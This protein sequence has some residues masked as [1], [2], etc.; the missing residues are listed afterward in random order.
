MK[1]HDR[2]S[3][4]KYFTAGTLRKILE[5]RRFRWSSPRV[6]NDPF[7]HLFQISMED[8]PRSLR[9][10]FISE[11]E[12]NIFGAEEPDIPHPCMHSGMLLMLRKY[13]PRLSR[14]EVLSELGHGFDEGVIRSEEYLRSVKRT[15]EEA[16]RT[17]RIFCVSEEPNNF[18]MWAHY[19][20]QHSGAVVE[21]RCIEDLDTPLCAARKV[22]YRTRMPKLGSN[23]EIL[24]NALGLA[25]EP[26]NE[27]LY[28]DLAFVKSDH[29]SYENEWRCI[30]Y[31]NEEGLYSDYKFYPQEIATVYLGCRIQAD[32][33][34]EIL[35]LLRSGFAHARVSLMQ[36]DY[37]EY[38]LNPIEVE[39]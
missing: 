8:D 11:C 7:D 3:F 13:S 19:A 16:I 17:A 12:R 29:W 4:Y 9:E 18:L 25:P 31:R 35:S 34:I 2:D 5:T 39:R 14:S 27:K 24:L 21:I 10:W 26:S 36:V 37:S 38:R 33:K 1:I 15:W 30:T 28:H 32:D 20:G 23:R 22:E 6:F